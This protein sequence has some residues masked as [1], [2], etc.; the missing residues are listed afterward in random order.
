MNVA[1]VERLRFPDLLRSKDG[2]LWIFMDTDPERKG[3]GKPYLR[4]HRL[5]E[6]KWVLPKDIDPNARRE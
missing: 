5:D 2:R 3:S 1:A 4:I 6:D